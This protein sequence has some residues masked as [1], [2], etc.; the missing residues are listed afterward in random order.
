MENWMKNVTLEMLPAPHREFA[1]VIG[2]EATLLLC[3]TYG[4]ASVYIPVIDSVRKVYRE[5]E[6]RRLHAAGMTTSSLARRFGISQRWVQ[7]LLKQTRE[8]GA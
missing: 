1:E 8:Q 2:V 6:I 7:R 3:E 4:L 5:S